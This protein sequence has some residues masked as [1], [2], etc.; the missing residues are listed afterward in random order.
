MYAKKE[1]FSPNII[2]DVY[3]IGITLLEHYSH[4]TLTFKKPKEIKDFLLKC[5]KHNDVG[6][7]YVKRWCIFKALLCE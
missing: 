2:S 6:D 4:R 3:M 7:K 1:K 5:G